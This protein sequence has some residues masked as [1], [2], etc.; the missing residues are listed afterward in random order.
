MDLAI[1]GQ[2]VLFHKVPVFWQIHAM[3]HAD[4]D[5]DVS[6]G[7]RFHPFEIMLSVVIK[8]AVIVLAGVPAMAV[9]VFEIV[10]NATSMFNHANMAL[11]TGLDRIVRL[12]VVTPDMHR[13]HHSVNAH[14][15]NSNFSFNLPWWDRLFGTYQAQPEAG[16]DGMSIGLTEFRG[17]RWRTI[18]GL[19]TLPFSQPDAE[20]RP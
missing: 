9:L 11:P 7:L 12:I 4:E 17:V 10:L 18:A 20:E 3:H 8:C 15:H 19:M 6:T 13:V 2:H 16:H 14:E 5:I 1:Y